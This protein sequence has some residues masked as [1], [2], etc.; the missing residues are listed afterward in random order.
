MSAL[1]N[2]FED[3]V[4]EIDL[5]FAFLRDVLDSDAELLFPRGRKRKQ[6][7]LDEEL[8]KIL[9]AN[10]YLLLYNLVESSVRNGLTRIYDIVRT[11]GRCY[12]DLRDELRY[13]WIHNNIN[14]DPARLVDTS[15]EKIRELL[16]SVVADEVMNFDPKYLP[17]SGN[18]DAAKV[19]EL[20]DRYGF[21]SKT[22]KTTQGGRHLLE[23]KTNRNNLAHGLKSFRECGRDSTYESLQAIRIQVVKYMRQIIANIDR[24]I[25]AKSYLEA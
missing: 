3:R 15:T 12:T 18:L 13:I 1:S 14:P 16:A 7:K 25:L 5:Y 8:L 11:E 20:S 17:I 9:K 23:V 19:R 10:A 24:Y 2:Q 4:E 22:S 6:E 21:S